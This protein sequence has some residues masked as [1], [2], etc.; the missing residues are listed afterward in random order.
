MGGIGLSVRPLLDELLLTSL[1]AME[2]LTL[3]D[4]FVGILTGFYPRKQMKGPSYLY[5]TRK[6][7]E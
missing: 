5:K 1:V 2:S 6:L 4:L 7:F 3:Q